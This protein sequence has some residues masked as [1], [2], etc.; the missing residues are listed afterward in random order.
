MEKTENRNAT[1]PFRWLNRPCLRMCALYIMRVWHMYRIPQQIKDC[2]VFHYYKMNCR[3]R[4]RTH[5]VVC[6]Q[7]LYRLFIITTATMKRL[8]FSIS[9]AHGMLVSI[10]S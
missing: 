2:A 8:I 5:L 9:K 6:P 1:T 3:M 4:K 10:I 7:K